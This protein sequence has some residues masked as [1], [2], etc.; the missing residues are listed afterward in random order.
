[1]EQYTSIWLA[2]AFLGNYVI[3]RFK[4]S[5]CKPMKYKQRLRECVNRLI[6]HRR[7][8]KIDVKILLDFRTAIEDIKLSGKIRRFKHVVDV[9]S[10]QLLT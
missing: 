2:K 10:C 8:Q 5:I 6:T 7:N 9:K 1:M 4:Y 3:S